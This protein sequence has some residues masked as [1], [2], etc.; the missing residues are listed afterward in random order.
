MF[1]HAQ[2]AINSLWIGDALSPLERL[3]IFSFLKNGH[4][5]NLYTYADVKNLPVG[6]NIK[7]ANSIIPN[8]YIF[9]TNGSLAHFSD[10]FRWKLLEMHGGYWVDMDMI[11]YKPFDFSE[12]IIFGVEEADKPNVAVLKFPPAHPLCKE[13]ADR[14]ENP[15]RIRSDDSTREKARKIFRKYIKSNDRGNI[16]WGEAGGPAG[17]GRTLL[18]HGLLNLAK[19]FTFFYPIHYANWQSIFNET[20]EKDSALFSDTYALHLWNENL[21]KKKIDKYAPFPEKS[22]IS[23]LIEKY[24]P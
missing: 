22:L 2:P 1:N 3:C 11:C 14:C 12:E 16:K 5:F 18:K 15:N 23:K 17:F 6:V 13:M 20:L 7:N 8:K 10:W 24:V 9:R 19:P 21:R 4:T